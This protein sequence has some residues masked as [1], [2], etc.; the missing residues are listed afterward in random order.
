[1]KGTTKLALGVGGL[2]AGVLVLARGRRRAPVSGVVALVG[3]RMLVGDA[4]PPPR[5]TIGARAGEEDGLV[6]LR[7]GETRYLSCTGRPCGHVLVILPVGEYEAYQRN[8]GTKHAGEAA[9]VDVDDR[10]AE[11]VVTWL[12][13]KGGHLELA[14]RAW[15]DGAELVAHVVASPPQHRFARF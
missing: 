9:L 11:T 1:M 3:E 7:P 10:K 6:V 4:G 15:P 12:V 14:A 5:P 8:L 2:F 13:C